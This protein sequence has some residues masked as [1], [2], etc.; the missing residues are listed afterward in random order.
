MNRLTKYKLIK[1]LAVLAI[2]LFAALL[3]ATLMGTKLGADDALMALA[4]SPENQED[5]SIVFQIRLPRAILGAMV[6]AALSLCGVVFQALLRNPLAD[7]FILG[8][9]GGASLGAILA[10]LLGTFSGGAVT[11]FMPI[12]I[13]PLMSFGG[14]LLAITLV[15]YMARYEGTLPVHTLLLS[16]VVVN[17]FFGAIIM[18][19]T[20]ILNEADL[21]RAVY[22]LMGNLQI[23]RY[24]GLVFFGGCL[25]LGG[26]VI[27]L[28]ARDY[29][30]LALGEEQAGHLGVNVNRVKRNS[31]IAAS[32]L[33][34]IA[35]AYAG[36]IG[37]VG[38]IVPHVLRLLVGSDHRILLPASALAG[39][40]FLVLADAASRAV[41]VH[42]VGD[43]RIAT[44]IPV[45]VI[46][47][48]TGG[49]FFIIL[50]RKNQKSIFWRG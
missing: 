40:I 31:I 33:T 15:Y 24:S 6:G 48:I 20:T 13:M 35:V 12:T 34:G 17:A 3:I 7:P 1:T 44:E 25:V 45:G 19:T 50:L 27:L 47:A 5:L 29:N 21:Q 9:S 11:S 49:P 18:F 2:L 30:A 36:P 10:I 28:R 39:A 16:G 23:I 32:L 22:Y 42:L 37:F 46:T 14:A 38:L 4:G 26:T 43:A 8:V 41:M